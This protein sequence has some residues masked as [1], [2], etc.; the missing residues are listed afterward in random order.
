MAS[1]TCIY[2]CLYLIT[3]LNQN[4]FL[5]AK[6][7][8]LVISSYLSSIPVAHL[9][10]I[11]RRKLVVTGDSARIQDETTEISWFFNMFGV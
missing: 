6:H 11:C 7:G 8:W 5:N 10:D 2:K 4:C 1:E 3:I 9:S